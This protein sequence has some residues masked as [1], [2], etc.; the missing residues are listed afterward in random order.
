LGCTLFG[1][2][3]AVGE[4]DLIGFL[5]PFRGY[6]LGLALAP[7]RVSGKGRTTSSLFRG[8]GIDEWLGSR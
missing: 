8:S 7:R 3:I 2:G 5:D 4:Q 1:T 6:F